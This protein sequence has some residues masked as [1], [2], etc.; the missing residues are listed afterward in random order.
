MTFSMQGFVQ[1]SGRLASG[2]AV[3]SD[4]VS[5]PTNLANGTGFGQ[6]NGYWSGTLVLPPGSDET[7]D[8][9]AL[10]VAFFGG[11]G[12][13]GLSAVKYLLIQNTSDKISLAVEP[14]DTNGWDQIGATAV[15][16]NGILHLWSPVTGLPVGGASRTIKVTNNGTIVTLNG[17]TTT[18][19]GSN[20]I[21]GLSSTSTLAVGMA[22]TG[23]GIP[24]GAKIASIT[25]S[26]TLVMTVS[27]TASSGSGGT[28]LDFAWPD[29]QV[30]IYVAGIL[31]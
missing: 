16:G 12:T 20:V 1:F 27:A 29:A 25:N 23:A 9:L 5:A 28:S 26:T 14:G 2:N 7:I 13:T 11:S 4:T 10:P 21:T 19:S 24:A 8:L 17:N 3:L 30:R 15:G 6:A 22:V 18:G 31:D